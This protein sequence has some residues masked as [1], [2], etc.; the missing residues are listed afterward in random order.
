LRAI[1]KKGP[2]R[3]AHLTQEIDV[4]TTTS[5]MKVTGGGSIDVN[6]DKGFVSGTNVEWKISGS[7]QN[8]ATGRPSPPFFGSIKISVSAN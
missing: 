5:Q 1:E 2:D 3:I 7:I 4:A 8:N 6:L